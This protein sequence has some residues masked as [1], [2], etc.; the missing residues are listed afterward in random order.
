MNKRVFWKRV[1]AMVFVAAI[2]LGTI[3]CGRVDDSP[4]Q[5]KGVHLKSAPAKTDYFV[6]EELQL[7]GALITAQYSDGSEKEVEV[8][9]DMISG[10]DP[11]KEGEQYVVVS[12]SDNGITKSVDFPVTVREYF[13]VHNGSVAKEGDVYSTTS[14]NT[15][16]TVSGGAFSEGKLSA[17]VTVKPNGDNGIVFGVSAEKESY[18]EEQVSYYFFFITRD[19][20][21]YLGKVTNGI[22]SAL[23]FTLIEQFDFSVQ[24]ELAVVKY[25]VADSYAVLQCYVDGKSYALV[26]DY[27]A[28]TGTGYGIRAGG[29]GVVYGALSVSLD[30]GEKEQVL[31]GG[32]IRNGSFTK[33]GEAFCSSV[34]NSLLSF[35]DKQFAYGVYSA[36]IKKNGSGDDGIVF[37]LSEN[38]IHSYWENGVSYYFFFISGRGTAY[39]GKASDGK[40]TVCGES[41]RIPDYSETGE[42]TLK[43]V[44]SEGSIACFIDDE[45]YIN[46]SD[47]MP[48]L[49]TATGVRASCEGVRFS[50]IRVEESGEFEFVAPSDFTVKSGEFNQTEN[51]IMSVR[52]KSL[53]VYKDGLENGTITVKMSPGSNT[54]NGIAFRISSASESFYE[55]EDGT[56][57]YFFHISTNRTARLIR[58]EGKKAT[59]CEEVALSAGYTSGSE[60]ELKVIFNGN[61]IKGYI[62]GA[63][64]VDYTDEAPLTGSGVGLRAS[65]AGVMIRDFTVSSETTPLK[66]DVVIFGHSHVEFWRNTQEDLASLG[67]VANLGVG[68]SAAV[69]WLDRVKHI[70]AYDP[71]Y[72]VMWLG[73][74][75]IAANVDENL[76]IQRLAT[77]LSG[78]REALPNAKIVIL[79]EFY[80]PGGGRETEAYRARI[81]SLNARFVTEFSAQYAICDVFDIVL[82]DGVL[83]ASM[84]VDVYHL[85]ADKYAPIKD[86]LLATIASLT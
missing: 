37:G 43:V 79:N 86:R 70:A 14:A 59:V 31:E 53:M 40:W 62:D 55:R 3:A 75:D 28:L 35:P 27:E 48:L 45:F 34:N 44:R 8:S 85:K 20:G 77:I 36:R 41:A 84:F 4:A 42:Y 18:W 58:L 30:A 80:Q 39:L 50:D 9:A 26:R 83:D 38:G 17:T 64:Y 11:D 46:F 10:Y 51:L 81:R 1:L 68:G 67:T 69:H 73:S 71:K 32:N 78:I 12:F 33:D 72:V 23:S 63:L 19:G 16:C 54:N 22:W 21:A 57:Y 56:C 7:D 47:S 65:A 25:D 24:H 61:N 60:S 82:K 6:G 49:G 76:I 15:L 66:A 74:N 13:T 29:T 5:L 2:A 52:D